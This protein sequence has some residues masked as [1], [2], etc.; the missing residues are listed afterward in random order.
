M[1]A[2][3]SQ[4]L[5]DDLDRFYGVKVMSQVAPDEEYDTIFEESA[6]K[7]SR[8]NECANCVLVSKC[9]GDG[10]RVRLPGLS[11]RTFP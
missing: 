1:P 8:E 2:Y 3:R 9:N 4:H 7:L 10:R 6:A 5:S 11:G